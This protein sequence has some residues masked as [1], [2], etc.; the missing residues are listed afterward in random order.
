MMLILKHEGQNRTP[1]CG[2]YKKKE[3]SGNKCP[4]ER[5]IDRGENDLIDPESSTWSDIRK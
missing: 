5:E 3:H 4:K 2:V 1:I